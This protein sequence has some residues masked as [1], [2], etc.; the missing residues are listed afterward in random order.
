MSFTQNSSSVHDNRRW[1]ALLKE[2]IDNIEQYFR[3]VD[4][5][6]SHHHIILFSC[7]KPVTV[8]QTT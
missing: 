7:D 6:I 3:K 2:E 4:S 5:K 1:D 8:N